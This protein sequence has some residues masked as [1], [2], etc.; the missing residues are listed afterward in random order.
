MGNFCNKSANPILNT[1]T[2]EVD[3]RLKRIYSQKEIEFWSTLHKL[4]F[5]KISEI[6]NKSVFFN[7]S[8]LMYENFLS[9]SAI[10][11]DL[12][13]N[14]NFFLFNN[15]FEILL[16]IIDIMQIIFYLKK[17]LGI[18]NFF[19]VNFNKFS[20]MKEP[21]TNHNFFCKLVYLDHK[22]ADY[23]NSPEIVV[24]EDTNLLS[25]FSFAN[26]SQAIKSLIN[27]N[28]TYN[29]INKNS[30]FLNNNTNSL[31]ELDSKL[32]YAKGDQINKF[33]LTNGIDDMNQGCDINSFFYSKCHERYK[34]LRENYNLESCEHFYSECLINFLM[35]FLIRKTLICDSMLSHDFYNFK[36]KLK[37]T[38]SYIIK[39]YNNKISLQNL[40]EI[41]SNFYLNNYE[42][43]LF[44]DKCER[45]LKNR[46]TQNTLL[47]EKIVLQENISVQLIY[48]ECD[49][50]NNLSNHNISFI[51]D[52][53]FKKDENSILNYKY[54]QVP[55]LDNHNNKIK[56]NS[57]RSISDIKINPNISI[58]INKEEG[59]AIENLQ[60]D[61]NGEYDLHNKRGSI[62]KSL[63]DKQNIDNKNY[64]FENSNKIIS[65]SKKTYVK[66]KE[67]L[68]YKSVICLSCSKKIFM[69]NLPSDIS[70][71]INLKNHYNEFLE[72]KYPNFGLENIINY[73][74][75]FFSM[76]ILKGN[77][78]KN[79][80][81]NL[82]YKNTL[83]NKSQNVS[84]AEKTINEPFNIFD[85]FIYFKEY[86][87]FY[88][89][90]KNEYS[91]VF[92]Y[93][94]DKNQKYIII[95][96]DEFCSLSEKKNRNSQI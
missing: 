6:K 35:K 81:N 70:N 43:N 87:K 28:N 83:I 49:I 73:I 44:K 13:R 93:E 37:N 15:I 40:K 59:T 56:F 45:I 32:K 57:S 94:K 90:K 72:K 26:S 46:D 33:D 34:R 8:D 71:M 47:F 7:F 76:E 24:K 54:N 39:N 53:Y 96:L 50:L 63:I 23:Y 29:N 42:Y 61:I 30:N 74:C 75:Y 9:L 88:L 68:P 20:L 14:E 31:F 52:T 10:M 12:I 69:N 19:L 62:R 95:S 36:T 89:Y 79:S 82:V 55:I 67:E 38:L 21:N 1:T 2:I 3:G 5:T 11:N 85:N 60:E 66:N 80:I 65:D 25:S 58:K 4:G 78:K 18:E 86:D 84:Y 48:G 77:E 27:S 16:A 22:L 41:L 17:K 64:D 51:Y 91:V 92:I